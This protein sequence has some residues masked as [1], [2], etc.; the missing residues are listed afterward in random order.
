MARTVSHG[1]AGAGETGDAARATTGGGLPAA[2]R[3]AL[4]GPAVRRLLALRAS[5][6]LTAGHVR[7]AADALGVSERTVWR[8]LAAAG[9][10]EAAAVEPGARAQSGERFTITPE[11]RGLL[12]LWKGNVAAVHRELTARAAR[13]SPPGCVPSLTTLHRALQRDLDP[14]ERAG[15]AGGERAARKHDVFLS[16]P[17]G[18]R[19]QVW[20]TDHVQAPLLV[21]VEGTARRPW[22]TWFTDCATNAITGLAVSP[23]YPSRESVLAA[24]RSA[25]L[26]EDPY[27]PF[28]GRP[29]KVRMDRGK[30]FLSAMVMTALDLLD[31]GVEDLPAYTPHLKGTVEG[32]NRAVESMF[33]AAL[34]GYARQPRPG[35]RPSRPRDEILLGFEEFTARLLEWVQWWNTSHRPAPLG[36]KTPLEAWQADPTPLRDVPATDVWTF[37]LEDAGTRTL[38]TRG[39]RFR[40][41]DYVAAW[42]TGKTGI[43]VQVR[44]MPHHDHRIEIFDPVTGR[45]L[46]PADLADQATEEQVSAVRRVRAARTRRLRKDLEASQRERYAAATEPGPPRRLGTLSAAEASRQLAQATESDLSQLALPDLIPPAAPPLDWRTPPS[47]AT[48]AAPGLPAATTTDPDPAPDGPP[49][50]PPHR[51]GDAP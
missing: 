17:R 9:R 10:D 47:L 26:R 18:W 16:R 5:G 3:T 25:V 49:A 27:G 32:L 51:T 34:P 23:G 7:V 30:D 35:K 21:D 4:R 19:N 45:Y 41:R 12:A 50:H 44:Y 2:S 38:T 28:G 48:R 1:G 14:G 22:I 33:L 20:E 37:T 42:M 13:Q 15:L 29:E 24:L 40:T 43:R 46:G 6:A 31:V 11:V 36:G 39:I 8:W